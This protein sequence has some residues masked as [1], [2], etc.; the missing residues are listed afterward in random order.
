MTR[1]RSQHC[2]RGQHLCLFSRQQ[3]IAYSSEETNGKA[4]TARL[5][6]LL[7]SL[8]SHWYW[9][10]NTKYFGS[11]WL[12]LARGKTRISQLVVSCFSWPYYLNCKLGGR[13]YKQRSCSL[14]RRVPCKPGQSSVDINDM[15][16]VTVS[17][18][19]VIWRVINTVDRVC[20][21]ALLL[22]AVKLSDH[23]LTLTANKCCN[24]WLCTTL[25][26][27]VNNIFNMKSQVLLKQW[28]SINQLV[29][30]NQ[31]RTC[32]KKDKFSN[33]LSPD[34][35]HRYVCLVSISHSYQVAFS[36]V[37]WRVLH[38]STGRGFTGGGGSCQV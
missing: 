11:F 4:D 15:P 9:L 38:P 10:I 18:T 13:E 17:L 6:E 19:G 16:P 25:T 8:Q 1:I 32:G 29:P 5:H 34:P 26:T 22:L 2:A 35:V 21:S 27:G 14:I 36:T 20:D 30:S 12:I 3:C 37:K 24:T 28:W 7:Q 33:M 31:G 23:R